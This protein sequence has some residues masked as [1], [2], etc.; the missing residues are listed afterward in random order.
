[1]SKD[2]QGSRQGE[3]IEEAPSPAPIGEL[4]PN[5]LK[6]VQDTEGVVD[7]EGVEEIIAPQEKAREDEGEG[8]DEVPP[9]P[10]TEKPKEP[11][12]QPD[13]YK[14]WLKSNIALFN[15]FDLLEGQD[16]IKDFYLNASNLKPGDINKVFIK[17]YILIYIKFKNNITKESLSDPGNETKAVLMYLDGLE[18]NEGDFLLKGEIKQKILD[19]TKTI[20]GNNHA[21]GPYYS[22]YARLTK[23]IEDFINSV[24]NEVASGGGKKRKQKRKSVRRSRKRV[25]WK[26]SPKKRTLKKRH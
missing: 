9:P 7:T 5:P 2:E 3:G 18:V 22:Y 4:N 23:G 25:S 10:A 12:P 21:L 26:R 11:R 6:L 17:L 15:I 1:M 19:T 8:E 20:P 16:K 13:K 24:F 14:S